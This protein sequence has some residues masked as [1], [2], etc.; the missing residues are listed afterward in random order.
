MRLTLERVKKTHNVDYLDN[1]IESGTPPQSGS[2][3]VADLLIKSFEKAIKIDIHRRKIFNMSRLD[4]WRL[5][6]VEDLV[7]SF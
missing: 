6:V 7:F 4:D 3:L 5:P 1:V 2:D